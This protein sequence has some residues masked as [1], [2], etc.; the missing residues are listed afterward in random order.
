MYV[1]SRLKVLESIPS[2][3][4]TACHLKTQAARISNIPQTSYIDGKRGGG[5]RQ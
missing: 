2:P 4:L 1:I 5:R 3:F